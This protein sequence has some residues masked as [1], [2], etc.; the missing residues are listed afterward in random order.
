MT[1]ENPAQSGMPFSGIRLKG[2]TQE[3]KLS[4]GIRY[5]GVCGMDA[6]V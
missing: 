4:R 2:T 1:N 3:L 6:A 5:E